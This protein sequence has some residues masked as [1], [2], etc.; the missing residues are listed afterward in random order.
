MTTRMCVCVNFSLCVCVYCGRLVCKWVHTSI[1]VHLKGYVR[2]VC[3]WLVILKIGSVNP[4][5][6]QIL[7]KYVTR[8][9]TILTLI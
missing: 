9:A 2:T 6:I 7:V 4:K 8:F 1:C 3:V 5:V